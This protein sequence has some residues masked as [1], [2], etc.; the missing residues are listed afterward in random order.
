[1]MMIIF[2][3]GQSYLQTQLIAAEHGVI[4]ADGS[5]LE[6][7]VGHAPVHPEVNGNQQH[8][9]AEDVHLRRES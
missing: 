1:M 6:V 4:V 5:H 8:V 9:V 3:G 7:H 2:K